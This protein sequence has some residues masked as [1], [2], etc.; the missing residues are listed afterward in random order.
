M[1][2]EVCAPQK[3]GDRIAADDVDFWSRPRARRFVRL[4]WLQRWT[5][6]VVG[7]GDQTEV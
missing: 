2:A 1:V 7:G 5:A 3:A 6:A 4:A